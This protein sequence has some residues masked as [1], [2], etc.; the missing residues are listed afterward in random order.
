MLVVNLYNNIFRMLSNDE[1]VLSY[2]QIGEDVDDL[3]V[4]KAKKI[5]KR[6]KP[7]EVTDN[8]PLIAFYAPPGRL[9]TE[10]YL[11]YNAPFVFD[12]YTYDDVDTAHKLAG[13]LSELFDRKLLSFSGVENFSSRFLTAYESSVDLENVYC[14]TAVFEFSAVLNEEG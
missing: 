12:I 1:I 3:L 7:Q 6:S 4:E 9:D 5:Q 8:I 2:L 11:V 14:F 10:N 13:R